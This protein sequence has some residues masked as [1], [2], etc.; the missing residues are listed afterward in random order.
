MYSR[1][2]A[3]REAGRQQRVIY[4]WAAGAY[5]HSYML[6]AVIYK[7]AAAS[8][9]HIHTCS[10]ITPPSPRSHSHM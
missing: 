9:I 3:E 2:C 8:N 7:W 1:L 6:A 10:L 5:T 4:K